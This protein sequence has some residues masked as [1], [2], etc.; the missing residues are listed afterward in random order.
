[1]SDGGVHSHLRHL[2]SLIEIAKKRLGFNS[3]VCGF[4]HA[5]TD[6][7]DTAPCSAKKFLIEDLGG[8]LESEVNEGFAQLGSVCGRYYAMDRD[9]R[10]ERTQLAYDA[11]TT[12]NC[13]KFDMKNL[14]KVIDE[15]YESGETDEFFKP[16][17][18]LED[19]LIKEDDCVIFF[20]FRSDRMRQICK[21]FIETELTR[22]ICTMTQY[23]QE[24]PFPVLSPP[25]QM[26]NVLAEWISKQ[27]L[28]QCHVAETEKYAHVTF[29]FNGGREDPFKGEERVL[30]SSPKVATY[31]LSPEM[32]SERV[33][34]AMAEAIHS[35]EFS[36]V[37][38]NLAP[39]DMV[40]HT[41]K[42]EETVKAVEAT[43]EAIGIIFE[44]CQ[45]KGVTLFITSDHGN[46]EK[47]CSEDGKPHTAHTCAPVPFICSDKTVTLN[48]TGALC[49]VAPS[50][51]KYMSIS[52]P[53]EMTGT[54][55]IN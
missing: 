13:D 36:F 19:S 4:I 5:I 25:Q 23:S 42:F 12:G 49:D 2:K 46:A 11:I 37:M 39:P 21:K 17:L 43:D 9:K 32:S 6:G 34:E 16:F 41:G 18:L 47:M 15:K 3:E 54:S 50:L 33:A 10:S 1:M 20:N 28:K 44:A 51:L 48:P 14:S 31:D 8:F 35:N 55:L 24:F 53:N 30:I 7:R 52:I 22:N 27:G 45:A 38:G 26:T 40:G 29:F